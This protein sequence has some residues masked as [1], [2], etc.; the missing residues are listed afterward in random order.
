VS[1]LV[2][3]VMPQVQ[4]M[5]VMRVAEM[6]AAGMTAAVAATMAA[7]AAAGG[8]VTGGRK[9]GG[10]Q[11]NGSNGNQEWACGFHGGRARG[12]R[13]VFERGQRFN[14]K[15][16]PGEHARASPSSRSAYM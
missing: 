15:T 3:A 13:R 10:S 14:E 2:V 8:C 11:R 16:R 6:A 5:A 4:M 7:M 1:L 9:R 12:D